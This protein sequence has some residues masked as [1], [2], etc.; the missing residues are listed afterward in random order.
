VGNGAGKQERNDAGIAPVLRKPVG[1]L[2]AKLHCE[3]IDFDHRRL[4]LFRWPGRIG[5]MA[6]TPANSGG[7][8]NF[9]GIAELRLI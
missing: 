2:V 9:G 6:S 4:C 5:I 3:Q 1:E 7:L 8:S